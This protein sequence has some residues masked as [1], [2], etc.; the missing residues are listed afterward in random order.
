[1]EGNNIN[2]S[3][4]STPTVQYEPYYS[5]PPLQSLE[6]NNHGIPG[7][8]P[9]QSSTQQN[10]Q[11]GYGTQ[12][13]PISADAMAFHPMPGQS[14]PFVNGLPKEPKGR[15]PQQFY[16]LEC[17]RESVSIIDYRFGIGSWVWSGGA[18]G[19]GLCCWCFCPLAL[20]PLIVEDC[21][22]A[23]HICPHCGKEAGRD[24][25]ILGKIYKD[26]P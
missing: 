20:G 21:K 6:Y 18:V 11:P 24:K 23:V 14:G 17:N 25:F 5:P 15:K 2:Q 9:P 10:F 1:M 13:G 12:Y 16:C 4:N 8:I 22:D 26:E 7:Y 3:V 19:T